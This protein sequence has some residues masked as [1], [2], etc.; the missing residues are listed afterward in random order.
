MD[1]MSVAANGYLYF[2]ANELQRQGSYHHGKDPGEAVPL[3]P[4]EN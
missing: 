3:V 1:T 2:T 4:R